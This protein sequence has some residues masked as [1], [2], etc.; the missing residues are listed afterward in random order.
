MTTYILRS[1]SY[2]LQRK[3]R[4]LAEHML[5]FNQP[6][7]YTRSDLERAVVR[8]EP[9]ARHVWNEENSGRLRASAL[10]SL[11]TCPKSAP[12]SWRGRSLKITAA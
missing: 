7:I 4:L 3:P 10:L 6:R 2:R 1:L 5:H 11:N 9:S 8:L 12:K